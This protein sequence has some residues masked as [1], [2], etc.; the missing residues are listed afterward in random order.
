MG[1]GPPGGGGNCGEARVCGIKKRR[2][3]VST[4]LNGGR[5]LERNIASIF[6]WRGGKEMG[7]QEIEKDL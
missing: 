5:R 6:E 4:L 3:A 2:K 1:G 7:C